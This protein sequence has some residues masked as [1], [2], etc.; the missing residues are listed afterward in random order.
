M[1][2]LLEQHKLELVQAE[3]ARDFYSSCVD[4]HKTCIQRLSGDVGLVETY[5][6]YVNRGK[7]KEEQ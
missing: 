3:E 5:N 6:K 4:Y 1:N 2:S 7:K